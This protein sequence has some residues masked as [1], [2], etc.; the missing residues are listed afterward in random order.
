MR[1]FSSFAFGGP[2]LLPSSSSRFASWPCQDLKTLKF[3]TSKQGWP[4]PLAGVIL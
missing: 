4:L 2:N 3:V 1:I